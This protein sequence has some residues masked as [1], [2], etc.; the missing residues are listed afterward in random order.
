VWNLT[1]RIQHRSTSRVSGP[2]EASPADAEGL[3]VGSM[4]SFT[5]EPDLSE[6]GNNL[7]PHHHEFSLPPVDR[8]KDAWLFLAACFVVEAL[9]WGKSLCVSLRLFTCLVIWEKCS[10]VLESR[11]L[12]NPGFPFSYGVFQEYYSTH[13]P[14]AGSG[15]IAVIGTC[16]MVSCTMPESAN[17]L[18][19]R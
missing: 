5:L 15:N 12:T 16:A 4:E 17:C 10:R 3:L 6:G 19:M 18:L 8:G 13:E 7:A 1:L 11:T 2:K 14:F 9:V